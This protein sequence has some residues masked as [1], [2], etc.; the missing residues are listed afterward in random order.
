M[1]SHGLNLTIGQIPHRH[2]ALHTR[3]DK[4]AVIEDADRFTWG[5]VSERTARL[6]NALSKMGVRKGHKVAVMLPNRAQ[7]VEIIYAVAGLGAAVVPISFRFVA[8]EVEYAVRHS[9]ASVVI[10]D[11]SLMDVISTA[12]QSLEHIAGDRIVV[13][14]NPQEPGGDRP[15]DYLDYDELL[16][17]SSSSKEYLV[18]DE[19]DTYHVAFTGGTTGYPKACEVNQRAARQGWYDI[20]IE[21]GVLEDDISLIPG[22]FYHSL[23]FMFGLQQLMV[24]GTLVMQRKFNAKGV[25]ELMER[26]KITFTTMA[27][28][29]YNMI[30]EIPESQSY[31]L[32]SVRGLVSAGAP[33]LSKTKE[34]LIHLFNKAG[35]YEFYASTEAGIYSVLKPHDQMRKV[36]SVGQAF[37]GCQIRILD[38]NGHDVPAGEMGE[39]YKKGPFL[40][41]S[42]YKNPEATAATLRGEWKTSGDIGR[43]DEEGYLYIVERTSDMIISGGVNIYPTEIEEILSRHPNVVEVAVVGLP[44]DKWG[45]TVNAYV[46]LRDGNTETFDELDS[47]CMKSMAAYKR[48]RQY[49]ALDE[50]PRN[51]AGKLLKRNLRQGIR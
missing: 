14:G 17:G 23:G 51:A 31:D 8:R 49:H 13:L 30:L 41:A 37:A 28:T 40:G 10:V 25:L 16:A 32:S 22:P 27:P 2:A 43:M 45:E 50:L 9:D 1:E 48:P 5:D 44:D 38:I 12:H 39:I 42:Y 15:D 26:E 20:T 6:A 3:R 47:L 18:L 4:Y 29:M 19:L 34:E 11:E 36:R 24:G 35:L 46:V 33:L 7:F 21:F